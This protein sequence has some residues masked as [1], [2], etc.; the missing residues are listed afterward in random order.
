MAK[1]FCTTRWHLVLKAAGKDEEALAALDQLCSIY[2][3]PVYGFVRRKGCSPEDAADLTQEFFAKLLRNNFAAGLTQEG[4]RFRSFL[5][6]ALNRFLVNEWEKGRR[7]K[8]GSGLAATSLDMLIAERGEASYVHELAHAESPECIYDRLW[9]DTVLQRVLGRLS[10][11]C[12]GTA[13]A[14]FDVL[15]P[16][17]APGDTPPSLAEAAQAL[18]LSLPAFKSLLHRF[19]QRYRELLLEEIG[20]TVA[21]PAEIADELRGLVAALRKC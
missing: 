17:L 7:A 21:S 20:Q 8:R 1:H 3:Y 9:A 2:W 14:R 15:K 18:A 13:K 12:E 19:R 5:L 16:F 11:E 10:A 6:T 4:G